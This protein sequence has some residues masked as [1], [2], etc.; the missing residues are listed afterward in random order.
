MKPSITN[1]LDST[2]RGLAL[3]VLCSLYF[4]GCSQEIE[5]ITPSTDVTA[6]Q[7]QI[8]W[9][10]GDVDA[11]FALAKSEAKPL[12]LYWGAEWC[13]PCHYLKDKIF[14]RPEFIAKTRNFVPVYLDGDDESA[15]AIG[16]KFGVHG[17]PTVIIFSSNGEEMM[18]MPS[19]I[20]VDQYTEILDRA[21]IMTRP[22]KK[23]L[24][25]VLA[26]GP[27]QSSE[28][29]L[30]LLS[31][32][33]W[34]QDEQVG[35]S[36]EERFDTFRRLYEE[37]PESLKI[38][39]SRF[40]T[41]FLGEAIERSGDEEYA[42]EMIIDPADRVAL[43]DAV[44][45]LLADPELLS[46]NLEWMF[47]WS[48][49]TIDLLEP[50]SGPE[51]LRI[52]ENWTDA[53]RRLELDESLSNDDRLSALLPQISIAKAAQPHSEAAT[54]LPPELVDRVRERVGWAAENVTDESELQSVMST[55]AYLL[56]QAG[57]ADEAETLLLEKFENA[58]APYYFMSWIASLKENSQDSS[59]A[60]D[61]YRRAYESSRGRY[62]RFRWGSSYLRKLL[63][64][65]PDDLDLIENQS[66]GILSDLLQ[67]SDAFS[68]GNHSRLQ[69]LGEALE[70]WNSSD[71]RAEVVARLRDLVHS[72]C[73][74]FP[75]GDGESAQS[76]CNA[77]L[78]S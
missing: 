33:A 35:L 16:E 61:W 68:G 50:T 67:L 18:R 27:R 75:A 31:Y 78:A 72:E 57:L 52:V 46:A 58:H 69:R 5:P 65:A 21:M 49:E 66:A 51:R 20:P 76:R 48:T 59:A 32:Y 12:F 36:A 6:E 28:A 29:D 60:I 41:Q 55:M 42:E 30:S 15:Q 22:I 71:D 39:K 8:A 45:A 47:Y 13:P 44:L 62:T 70:E 1:Q 4:G 54:D 73:D 37:T 9:H 23:V 64:L 63:S 3:T 43:R 7:D 17:Y 2:I 19:S 14:K 53:A 24:A 56:G 10:H 77:F 26:N 38:E 74:R 34:D 40:L 25:D 11:A